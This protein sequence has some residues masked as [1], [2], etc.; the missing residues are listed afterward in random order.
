MFA[1]KG[2]RFCGPGRFELLTMLLVRA[3]TVAQQHHP[4]SA[5]M[6]AP[7]INF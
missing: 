1:G 7:T 6:N 3:G 5:R 2:S 4:K